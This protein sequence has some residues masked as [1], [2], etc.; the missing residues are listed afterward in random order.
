MIADFNGEEKAE[1]NT[2]IEPMR[3]RSGRERGESQG[4]NTGKKQNETFTDA[5]QVDDL[6]KMETMEQEETTESSHHP[7][8]AEDNIWTDAM[9]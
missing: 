9:M 4:D 3:S 5:A 8:P 7:Q 1:R 6:S 2:A